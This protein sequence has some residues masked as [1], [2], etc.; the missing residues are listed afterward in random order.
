MRRLFIV[1]GLGAVLSLGFV[2]YPLLPAL[3]PSP[4]PA[5][6]Y[7]Y[8]TSEAPTPAPQ[9]VHVEYETLVEQVIPAAG[10]TVDVT[11]GD[12]GQRLVESGAVDLAKFEELYGGLTPE[13]QEILQ[14]D[15]LQEITFT[16]DNIQFWTNV[17]W[18]FGLTQRSQVLSEGPMMEN[19]E[20]IPLGNY[21]STG[22]WDLGS[23]DA[24]D[25]YN[26]TDLITLTP[27]QDE[28]VYLVAENIFRPCCGN[29]TVFP[30][31]NHGMAVLGLLELMA[32]QGADD[33]AMYQAA[34]A[35]NSYAFPSTYITLAAYFAGQDTDWA[36]V[37]PVIA[38]GPNYSSGQ[39][40]QRIAAVVGPIPGAPA[41][42]GS[43][44]T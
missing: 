32:A 8:G 21:A 41:Q 33:E 26:S 13:Q 17:L 3:N 22:G 27:E 35:F 25:L 30:D 16:S 43:C 19:S 34:L 36:D 7:P 15:S 40:F 23:M 1:L 4:F 37:S 38:L 28:R 42:G 31:C 14:G 12:M 2:V 39:G 9:V 20:E 5:Q 18:A 44:S 10:R 24:V 29:P 6:V 11:W